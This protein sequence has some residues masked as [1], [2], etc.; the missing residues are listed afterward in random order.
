MI[1]PLLSLLFRFSNESSW[2][3]KVPGQFVEID[4][5]MERTVE[6]EVVR[7]GG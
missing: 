4:E 6:F 2:I 3:V 1:M 5:F 7:L